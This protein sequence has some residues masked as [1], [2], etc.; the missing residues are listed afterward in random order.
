MDPE[1]RD[2]NLTSQQF[3]AIA[4]GPQN[5]S[6]QSVQTIHT[7][8]DEP[9]ESAII[10][11]PTDPDTVFVVGLNAE[12]MAVLRGW[13]LE[14]T[15]NVLYIPSF[16]QTTLSLAEPLDMAPEIPTTTDTDSITKTATTTAGST[17]TTESTTTESTPTT[18]P[19]TTESTPTT[20]TASTVSSSTYSEQCATR[21]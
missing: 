3:G 9:N 8:Q 21:R 2:E 10:G 5:Q 13:T 12:R 18:E 15:Q 17:P 1:G 20:Q 6:N 16:Y 14:N 11:F 4:Y 7:V 19:T